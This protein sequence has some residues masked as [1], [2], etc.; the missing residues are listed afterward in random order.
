[1]SN[2]SKVPD[3][4]DYRSFLHT[5]LDGTG[6]QITKVP[7]I[8]PI[9]YLG[10]LLLR[11]SCEVK[12]TAI[13]S[14]SIT[15]TL[16][17][18]TRDSIETSVHDGVHFKRWMNTKVYSIQSMHRDDMSTTC[19]P[20]WPSLLIRRYALRTLVTTLCVV[21]GLEV[22]GQSSEQGCNFARRYF[23][24]LS[25]WLCESQLVIYRWIVELPLLLLLLVAWVVKLKSCWN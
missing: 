23:N 11:I 8:Q 10:S 12:Y 15:Q 17:Q 20:M 22:I 25:L 6:Y 3:G 1:M 18:E 16:R 4:D 5:L 9:C 2:S 19:L 14:L 21:S 24:R 7:W 13:V